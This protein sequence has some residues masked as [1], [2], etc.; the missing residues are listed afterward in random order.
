[1]ENNIRSQRILA[2]GIR[3][4]NNTWDTGLNNNDLLVGPSGG[5]K[6][7]GYVIPNILHTRD[8]L[9]V[10]DTTGNLCRLYG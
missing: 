8:S 1:M 9:I 3:V 6:T 5:G 4:S 7:R 2:K 10:T